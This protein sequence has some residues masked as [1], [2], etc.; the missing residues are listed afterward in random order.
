MVMV[1][2]M[3]KISRM[4]PTLIV[5]EIIQVHLLR[6]MT[7]KV[8]RSYIPAAVLLPGYL[9]NHVEQSKTEYLLTAYTVPWYL[10]SLISLLLGTQQK[11]I[12]C[13]SLI[14]LLLQKLYKI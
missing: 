5:Q 13:V 1:V 12:N 8:P 2:M 7:L 14:S 3:F 9:Q 10:S 11:G 4:L 6:Y